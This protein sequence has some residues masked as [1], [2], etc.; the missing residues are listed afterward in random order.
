LIGTVDKFAMLAWS[1]RARSIFGID[2]SGRHKGRPP[3]LVIQDELHLISGPLG[4]MVGAY[5]TVIEALCIDPLGGMVRPKIV[6]S[7]ATIS[8]A[9]EQ[10]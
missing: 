8:R 4:S 6:A 3:T 9:R 7:T 5:E 1:P 2:E 10:V